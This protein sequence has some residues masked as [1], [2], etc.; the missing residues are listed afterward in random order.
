MTGAI[1]SG[2]FPP[3]P[4]TEISNGVGLFVYDIDR[5]IRRSVALHT[6]H[7]FLESRRGR[8]AT[9]GHSSS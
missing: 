4:W 9:P 8:K 6:L 2:T 1:V 5:G 7:C 3:S